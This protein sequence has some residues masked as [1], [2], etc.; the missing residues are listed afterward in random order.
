[1][2][3]AAPTRPMAAD[4][5]LRWDDGG[6]TRHELVHGRPV[7][8]AP[9]ADRQGRIAVNVAVEIDRRLAER[10]PCCG[11]VEGGVG[12]DDANVYVPDVVA[13]C[14]RPSDDGRVGEPFL[15]VEIIAPSNEKDELSTKVQAYIKLGHVNEIWLVDSR[16][17]WVQQ[18]RRAGTDSWIVG[19]PLAG[20]SH[21]ASPT[22]GDDIALDRLYRNTEL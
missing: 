12:I 1:M 21:F 14:A 4:E 15:I 18:W 17:R 22:L 13:T 2:A 10:P 16:Q 11:I 8:M 3:D 19:L 9:A 7:A 20:D 6:D 5:F